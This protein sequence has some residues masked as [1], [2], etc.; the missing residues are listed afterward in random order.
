MGVVGALQ[1]SRCRWVKLW[2]GGGLGGFYPKALR[3]HVLRLL[4]RK[5]RLYKAFGPEDHII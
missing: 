5:T 1:K 3:T 2:V 4:G